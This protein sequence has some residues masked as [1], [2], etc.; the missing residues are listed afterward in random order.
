MVTYLMS[1]SLFEPRDR[2][3]VLMGS[4]LYLQHRTVHAVGTQLVFTEQ[5]DGWTDA[6]MAKQTAPLWEG[7]DQLTSGHQ[8]VRWH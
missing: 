3:H 8:A 1:V 2:D 7:G 5:I 6:W 4:L